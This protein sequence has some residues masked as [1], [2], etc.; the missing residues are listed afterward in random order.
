MNITVVGTGRAG[1]SFE[2]ALRRAG[3]EV[4]VAHH[5]ETVDTRGVDLVLLCVPDDA[6]S[7][8]A[9]SLAPG[10]FVLAHVAGSRGLGELAPH[11]R[12]GSLHPLAAL[13]SGALGAR[14]LVGATYC[15]A[16]DPLVRD[17]V[18]SLGG[19]AR[20]VDDAH[21]TLYHAT[22]AV[23]ANHLVALMG[24]VGELADSAGLTL[25][26]FLPL[27]HQ[28]LEDVARVGPVDALTGP[29]SRGDA[30]TIEAHLDAL[31][32]A[33]RPAYVALAHVAF[34]LAERRRSQLPA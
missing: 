12:V 8:T 15:V 26:D 3:H 20:V 25:D 1:A 5:D 34:E 21:R 11:R 32:D 29:A 2:L 17:V 4:R 16:G 28:A 27:A 13:P 33:H 22:A 9:R 18:A 6:I 23:A 14:R 24:Y 10:N 30:A 31:D 19:R 7:E